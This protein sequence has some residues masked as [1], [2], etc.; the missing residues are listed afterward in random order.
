MILTELVP[1][2][3]SISASVFISEPGKMVGYTI[4]NT[5]GVLATVCNSTISASL[6][7]IMSK[8][9]GLKPESTTYTR[10]EPFKYTYKDGNKRIADKDNSEDALAAT[11][12]NTN[13]MPS[14]YLV[15]D[16]VLTKFTDI[17]HDE[18]VK[19]VV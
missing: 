2:L 10:Q 3:V 7:G 12:F 6:F 11:M 1:I 19:E 15:S 17:R 14:V 4:N 18:S 5:I 9:L 13:I 8:S 16:V